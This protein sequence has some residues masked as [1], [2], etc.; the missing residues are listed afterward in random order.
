MDGKLDNLSSELM[1]V[2]V[3]VEGIAVKVDGLESKMRDGATQTDFQQI[4][5][6]VQALDKG[7]EN[8]EF[9]VCGIFVGLVVL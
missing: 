7:V 6:K 1:E 4:D 5:D 9:P 2:K 3:R 8:L